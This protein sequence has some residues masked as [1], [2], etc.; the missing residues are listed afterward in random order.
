MNKLFLALPLLILCASAHAQVNALSCSQVDVQSAITTATAS[1]TVNVPAGNCSWTLNGVTLNKAITLNGAGQGVTNITMTAHPSFIITRQASGITRIQN[2]SYSGVGPEQSTHFVQINGPWP[3]GDPVIFQNIG[4]NVNGA[5]MFQQTI[6]GGVIYSHIAFVG[7]WDNAMLT[8]KDLTHTASW[9]T[10]NSLG[11]N[12]TTGRL[13][14]YVEDVTFVGGSNGVVDCDDNCRI[15]WRH[16]SMGFN[17]QD[18]GGFNSHGEDTSPYGMRQFEIY[19]NTFAFPDKTAPLGNSSLSNINQFIWI[20]GGSG[21]IQNNSIAH[22]SSQAWGTKT[23]VKLSNRGAE[24]ARPAGANCGSTTYPVVHQIGQDNNGS[25]D[26]TSPIYFSGNTPDASGIINVSAAWSWGNPC[27]FDWNTFFGWGRDAI[28]TSVGSPVLPSGGGSVTGTGGTP[29]P[30]YTTFAYPHPL[31]AT[32]SSPVMAFSPLTSGAVAFG[33]VNVGVTSSPVTVTISN[34]GSATET[35]TALGTSGGNVGDWTKTGG[36]CATPS[37]TIAQSASC[38]LIYTFTPAAQGA[39]STTLTI[40]GTVTAS[41]AFTGAGQTS[42]S[43]PSVPAGLTATAI[44]AAVN[45][46]WSA[47]TGTP[48]RYNVSRSTVTGGPYTQI[49]T[50]TVTSYSDTGLANGTYFYVVSAHNSAGTSANSTQVSATVNTQPN[51]NLTPASLAFVNGTV[52]LISVAQTTTLTNTGTATLSSINV[53]NPS[54]P[55]GADFAQTNNCASTLAINASCVI[56]V[57]ETPSTTAQETASIVVTSSD[58]LSP[59]TLALSGTATFANVTAL[60]A[61]LAFGNIRNGKSSATQ[62][63]T[64]TNNSGQIVTFSSVA[65]TGGDSSQF[66]IDTNNCTSTLASGLNCTVILHF[67]PTTAGNKAST[68]A[69]TYTG[70]AAV[71]AVTLTGSG[72]GKKIARSL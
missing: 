55:N 5:S 69:F 14:T 38:T 30:G 39:R 41:V 36:T 58:P 2:M 46:S 29:K 64:F 12:D 4:I 22:L 43:I 20:R 6:A 33:T 24:D 70:T 66:T 67:H 53:A 71:P 57:T 54:G 34:I 65:V 42:I 21:V 40:T 27:G 47:S 35:Y 62:T 23:E 13:N 28:N 49:A 10:A 19:S 45:L 59:D 60:P 31:L 1:Q 7:T 25:S 15:V 9:T 16:N 37:G 61:S 63:V 72:I 51:A 56:S 8:V 26:V 68:L 11:T 18:S 48:D 52:G 17:G 32:A 44:G 50:P 3:T